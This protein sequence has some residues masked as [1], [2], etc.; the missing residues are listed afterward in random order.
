MAKNILWVLG[1]FFLFSCS[2]QKSV[3][4][5]VHNAK[6][7]TVDNQFTVA[8]AFAVK[9]GKILEVGASKDILSKYQGETLDAEGNAIFPGFIDGHAHF[10]GYGAGLQN[11]NLVGTK[12]WDEILEKLKA[13]SIENPEG[14]IIGRGWDQNDWPTKEFPDNQKLNELFPNRPVILSRVDGHAAIANKFALDLAGLKPNQKIEGGE[15]ETV[16]GKLTGILVDNAEGLVVSKI[17]APSAK[18]IRESLLDAQRNCFAV[19][20]TTVTDCGISHELIP[21]IS[22]LQKENQLKM[23]IYGMLSDNAANYEYLF[24]NG[25]VKTERLNI[26]SF[27]VYMDGALGSRG[28]CLLE[29]YSDKASTSGFLLSA[30]THFEEVAKKIAEKGF[31][32]NTHAIGDSANREILSIYGRVLKGKNDARWRIEHAQVVNQEDFKLFG[33]NSVIPSVQSTHATSDMYWAADRLGSERVKGAYAFKQLLDQNGWLVLGTDF[34]VEDINPMFTFYSAVVRKDQKNYPETGFQMENSLS[35]EEAIRG[36]TIW[37]AKGNFEEK[38]KGS[39]EVGKF[40]D[41]I[42]L[43][44]DLMKADAANLFKTKVLKT[45]LNGEKVYAK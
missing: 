13:F 36:M 29:P 42:I 40:A 21:I 28:A 44:Q 32:M 25:A 24:K 17:P 1:T 20:L 14:W 11:A 23:R 30:K 37:A 41:F 6:V 19:G 4:L 39:L 43:D 31:Q 45:Y 2:S 26:R 9:D 10:Y 18:Q 27:K 16:Q 22:D 7:Y 38:E 3:D 5:I 8:E 34:P 33:N 12:S 35:R 15:I